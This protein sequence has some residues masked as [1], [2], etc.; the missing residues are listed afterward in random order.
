MCVTPG[1]GDEQASDPPVPV[2][3]GQSQRAALVAAQAAL[4]A[5]EPRQPQRGAHEAAP[6]PAEK[7]EDVM[8]PS[9]EHECAPPSPAEEER[10]R[11]AYE[12]RRVLT[13]PRHVLMV[14]GLIAAIFLTGYFCG[15]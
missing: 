9:H 13:S 8:S 5:Q 6:E 1:G 10:A 12:R 11:R 14:A 7:E 15:W 3:Q 2:A 4:D